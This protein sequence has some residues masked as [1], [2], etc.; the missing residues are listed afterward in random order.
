MGEN[1]SSQLRRWLILT[2][3]YAPEIGA[4]QIRLRCFASELRKRAID[5]SVLTAMPS[6]PLGKVF[7]EYAGRWR[8][9][10]KIDGIEV[11]RLWG[12][13]A[14]GKATAARIANYCG[15][16]LSGLTTLF[17]RS[18]PDVIFVES[19]PLPVGIVPLLMKWL[20]GVP[21][22]YNIPDLQIQAVQDLGF[23]DGPVLKFASW[24][25]D[26]LLKQAWKISTVTPGFI[27][28]YLSRGVPAEKI[29]FLPNGADTEFLKPLPPSPE[30]LENWGL[31]GKKVI[32]AVGTMTYYQALD[33]IIEAAERLSC[34]PKIVILMVGDGPERTRIQSLV[35]RKGL[36]NVVFKLLPYEENDRLYSIAWAALATLRDVAIAQTSRPSK[37]FPP[38]SCGVPVIYSGNGEAARLLASNHCGITVPPEDPS[39][40]AQAIRDLVNDPERRQ[41]LGQNGRLLAESEYSWSG[42]VER[43]LNEL[44]RPDRD[45]VIV[46][47]RS[48]RKQATKV[49]AWAQLAQQAES[50]DHDAVFTE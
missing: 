15:F 35:K 40:L 34:D 24:F 44:I 41:R 50:G 10:E 46:G 13:A 30:L 21:Y 37:L 5:V 42:I 22:I 8:V 17:R 29:T 19:Q 20:R 28:H 16:A 2:Q 23:L 9:D 12:H 39:A 7:K 47:G 14:T 33:T 43:W 36:S 45:L 3:Y 48:R 6:Y 49:E 26:L 27:D 31:Q 38:L 11:R 4:P 32:V 1:G 18:L 25:E